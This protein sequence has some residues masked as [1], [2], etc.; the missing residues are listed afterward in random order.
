[1]TVRWRI[2]LSFLAVLLGL[3]ANEGVYLWAVDARTTSLMALDRARSRQL[4][5]ALLHREVDDLR[6]EIPLPTRAPNG[7]QVEPPATEARA[8][9]LQARA[10]IDTQLQ[11]LRELAEPAQSSR[12]AD[13]T[14]ACTDLADSWVAF[15]TAAGLDETAALAHLANSE[16][17]AQRALNEL[18][19]ALQRAEA[20]RVDQALTEFLSVGQ[21]TGAMTLGFF[22]LS[23]AIGLVVAYLLSRHLVI[24]LQDLRQGAALIGAVNLD[25]RIEIRSKDELGM[26][27]QAFNEMAEKLQRAYADLVAMNEDLLRSE[28]RLRQSQKM[29]AIGRLAGGVAHDFN[30]LLTVIKGHTERILAAPQF[31]AALRP[32]LT[33]VERAAE[34]AAA[35]TRQLLIFSRRQV[36]T[37]K[38]LDLSAVVS[39]LSTVL[40]SLVGDEVRLVTELDPAPGHLST[41]PGQLDQ[42]IMNLAANARDA[43]PAGGVLTIRTS[44]VD[45]DARS[46]RKRVD[47]PPGRY[48]RLSM[49]D[50]GVGMDAETRRMMFDPFFTTK[51]AGKGTGLGLSTVYG[52]VRQSGGDVWV[53]S[54]MGSGTTIEVYFPRVEEEPDE[55]SAASVPAETARG[56]EMILLVEDDAAVRE[57]IQSFLEESGYQ[58][59]A[60]GET[61]VAEQLCR[62]HRGPIALLLSDVVLQDGSGP[63]LAEALMPLRPSMRVLFM[64]GYTD[65]VTF[66]RGLHDHST[67]FLQKP[68][69]LQVLSEKIREVLDAG[70]SPT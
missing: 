20:G 8:E 16:R 22:G 23:L 25:H 17:L 44:N 9:F 19:P 45:L 57:L 41:D 56:K 10:A 58:V 32:R 68:F 12:I 14:S 27:A 5:L 69:T 29:E 65:D 21:F 28:E 26:L 54:T 49:S 70:Q 38:V 35:L 50:T 62:D 7:R 31:A 2:T 4:A 66:K 30:N 61:D 53:D 46:V 37:P 67:A 48:V 42:V 34:R 59:L 43:M 39:N 15:Y 24:A 47:L 6:K 64:S 52:I 51:E 36:L 18:I 55:G 63:S 60:A 40:R 1:M 13:L 33:E 11:R 3:A